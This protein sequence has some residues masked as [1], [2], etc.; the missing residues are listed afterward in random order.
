MTRVELTDDELTLLDGK[1]SDAVQAD[2]DAAKLRLASVESL[3]HLTPERAGFVADVVREALKSGRLTFCW[4]SLRLCD[5][6]KRS[7]GYAPY[8]RTSRYRRKGDPDYSRPRTFRGVELKHGYVSV[9]GYARLGCC[10]DCFNATKASLT[11]ALADI[12]AEVPEAITGQ[13]PRFRYSE[14]QHCTTCDWKGHELQ[15]G[16]L[17]TLMGDGYYRGKC[18]KCGAENRLFL[19]PIKR[20]DGFQLVA[21]NKPAVSPTPRSIQGGESE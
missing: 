4:R 13:P 3:G 11:E 1:C 16:Q 7:D 12:R 18:P 9:Q 2:V 8:K 10:E 19:H 5:V 15:L 20:V 21:T 17:P 6:C 14:N